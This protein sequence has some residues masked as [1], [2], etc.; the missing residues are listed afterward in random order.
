MPDGSIMTDG[1][2]QATDLLQVGVIT[3]PHGVRG[4]VKVKSFTADPSDLTAYGPLTDETGSSAFDLDIRGEAKGQ[5]I[6]K[7]DGVEDRNKA[8]LLKGTKLFISRAALP[9]PEEDEFYHADLIGLATVLPDGSEHGRVSAVHDFGAGDLLEI[10]IAGGGTVY[11]PFTLDA[12]PNVDL[13]AGRVTVDPPAE[14][15]VEGEKR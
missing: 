4:L 10:A 1:K 6:I 13:A 7:V 3:G 12:V 9:Q 5:F 15:E 8:E 14:V 11:L 2:R